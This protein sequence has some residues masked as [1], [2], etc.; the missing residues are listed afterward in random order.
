MSFNII[1]RDANTLINIAY[2]IGLFGA[3]NQVMSH[4]TLYVK[5][6]PYCIPLILALFFVLLWHAYIFTFTHAVRPIVQA[7]YPHYTLREIDSHYA[8]LGTLHPSNILAIAL[9]LVYVALGLVI[10]GAVW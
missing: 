6:Y 8:P 3:I 9:S 4:A 5:E 2:P 10:T 7:Y 1:M